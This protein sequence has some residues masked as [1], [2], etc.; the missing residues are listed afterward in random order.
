MAVNV[1]EVLV[2][3][4]QNPGNQG[5]IIGEEHV[6]SVGVIHPAEVKTRIIL[7]IPQRG[8]IILPT[9]E[10]S[11]QGRCVEHRDDVSKSDDNHDAASENQ[12]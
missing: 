11:S 10:A 3:P 2:Y 6:L 1:N 12:E 4:A 5:L 8:K 7:D 9:I